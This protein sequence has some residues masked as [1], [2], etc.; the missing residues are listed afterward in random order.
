MKYV[1]IDDEPLARENVQLLVRQ[2]R[3]DLEWIGEASGVAEGRELILSKQPHLLFLDIQ[4]G[5]G[6]GFELLESL[7]NRNFEIIFVTAY[8]T[9]S[10]RAFEVAALDY[11]LKPIDM[12][13]LAQGLN[14]LGERMLQP[15]Q[16]HIAHQAFSKD[17][18]S[19]LLLRTQNG[20]LVAP[21]ADIIRCEADANYT[22]VHFQQGKPILSSHVLAHYES[23]LAENEFVRVHDKHLVNL[24]FVKRY[25]KGRGGMLELTDGSMV[26][27]SVRKRDN[28]FEAMNRFAKGWR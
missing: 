19:R 25:H 5:D 22:R 20:F 24:V 13:R 2:V 10:I 23:L 7:P 1:V 15:D 4:L 28:F 12:K 8:E 17:R 16:L 3:P 21:I 11:L 9:H 27:V 14:R 6:N 26:D 18:L